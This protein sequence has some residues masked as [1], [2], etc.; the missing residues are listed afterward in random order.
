MTSRWQGKIKLKGLNGKTLS[1]T[2]DLGEFTGADFGAEALLAQSALGQISGAL[3]DVT[4]AEIAEESLSNVVPYTVG[5]LGDLFENA[6]VNVWTLDEDDP[7]ALEH[8]SQIYIPAPVDSIFQTPSGPGHDIVDV[9]NATL[10]QY[11]EQVADHAFVSDGETIQ[12]G[13]GVDGMIDGRR[14]VRKVRLGR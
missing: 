13:S 7:T 1:K 3:G 9:T 10:E 12:Q 5:G 6:M 4:Q 14:V 8:I 11:V 2:Y